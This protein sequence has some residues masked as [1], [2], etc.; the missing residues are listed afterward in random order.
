[1][2][3]VLVVDDYEDICR[4]LCKTLQSKGFSASYVLT[5]T[6]A[7]KSVF[8]ESPDI[9]LLD[10][11]LPGEDGV[12]VLRELRDGG[13]TGRVVMLTAI[14]D[15]QTRDACMALGAN[16]Y[17]VKANIDYRNIDK[18]ILAD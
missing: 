4:P 13:Y 1:M 15:Q 16:D 18:V 10:I 11:M 17:L 5:G 2:K 14:D 6:G 9:V 3:T 12:D 7:I 8:H